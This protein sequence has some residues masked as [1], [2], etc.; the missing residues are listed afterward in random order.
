M[1]KPEIR[2][3]IIATV[4]IREVFKITK[5]GM[6]AGCYVT[7]GTLSRGSKARIIRDDVEIADTRI[8]TLRRHQDDVREVQNNHECG[9]TVD[10]FGDFRPGDRLEAYEE[11]EIARK[12]SS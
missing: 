4:E 1:G 7:T 12:L 11:V 8:A 5:I 3:T 10:K 6:V 2:E 9:L